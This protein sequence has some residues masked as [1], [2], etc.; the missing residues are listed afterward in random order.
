MKRFIDLLK[1]KAA[2]GE[3]LS[4]DEKAAKKPLI[5]EISDMFGNEMAENMKKVTVVAPD[6]EGLEEGLEKAAEVVESGEIEELEEE[7]EELSKD[8]KI[9]QLRAELAELEE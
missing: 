6:Q 3:Y 5:D 1:E 7:A 4:E 9:A 8:D 2:K